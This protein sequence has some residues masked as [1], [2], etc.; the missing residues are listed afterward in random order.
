MK[1]SIR[2]KIIFA[3]VLC[4]MM[5]MLLIIPSEASVKTLKVYKKAFPEMAPKCVYCHV[6]EKPKKD[7]GKHELNAYGLMLKK[8]LGEV[9]EKA[10]E[11]TFKEIGSHEQFEAGNTK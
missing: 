1:K 11:E 3:F 10:T 9:E 4:P 6:D 5:I 2:M 7:E 8:E